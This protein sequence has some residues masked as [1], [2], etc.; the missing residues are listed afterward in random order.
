MENT[1]HLAWVAIFVLIELGEKVQKVSRAILPVGY[2]YI[3]GIQLLLVIE[4]IELMVRYFPT[5]LL[6]FK[7]I[8]MLI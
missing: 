7:F 5:I 4:F 6:F 3:E 2:A 8:I 1:Y